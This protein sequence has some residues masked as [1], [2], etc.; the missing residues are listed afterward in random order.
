MDVRP[1]LVEER[2]RRPGL[3]ASRR[4]V[5]IAEPPPRKSATPEPWNRSARMRATAA[6]LLVSLCAALP[7]TVRAATEQIIASGDVGAELA[8]DGAGRAFLVSPSTWHSAGT[9][10]AVSTRSAGRGALFGPSRMLMHSSHTE[11]AVDAGV[12]ADGSGVIVVQRARRSDR[13]LRVVPFRAHGPVGR[14]VTISSAGDRADFAASAV[15]RSGAAVVVWFRHSTHRR[16]RLEAALREAGAA[17]FGAPAPVSAFA[18]RACCTNVSVAIGERGDAAVTWASTSR[19]GVWAT[20]RRPGGGFRAPQRLAKDASDVPKA[21]V[22]PDGTAVVIYSRQHV[23]RRADDG[24]ALHRAASSGA[25]GAPAQVNP[26]GGVTLADAAVTPGGRVIVA[27]VDQVHGAHVHL[28]EAGGGEPL[29]ATG[30]LGRNVTPHGV[31]VA[32]DDDGRAVL[33]WSEVTSTASL[34]R[35]QAV[36]AT[37]PGSGA[38]FGPAVALGRPWRVASPGLARLVPG[39]GALVVWRGAQFG[40]GA[41]RRAQL[42]V[43]RLL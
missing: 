40:G 4:L 18:R 35:E 36:A 17:A 34:Y 43:T 22:G 12:A 29:V 39:G 33:A 38:A 8:V 41:K 13:R 28:W 24:L 14:P 23:P 21:V 42:A 20:L 5:T 30:E 9:F 26:G 31:A 10:S 15:A 19:P 16:W 11:R 32:A 1:A 3:Q 37:R 7:S 6:C 2:A 25:F 27:W